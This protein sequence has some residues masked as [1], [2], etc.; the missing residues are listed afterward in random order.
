MSLRI[1]YG[2]AGSGKSEFCFEEI[3]SKQNENCYMITPEQF[4]F[5]AEQKLLETIKTGSSI[6]SEVI[7]F[8]RMANRVL[9]EVGGIT[10]NILSENGKK[11]LLYDILS[12]GKDKLTF[13]GKSE[14]NV[15]LIIKTLTEFKKHCI[16]QDTLKQTIEKVQDARLKLKLQD[17]SYCYD[18]FQM[19]LGTTYIEENDILS[20]LPEKLEHSKMFDESNVYIDEF[21]GFTLQEYAIIEAILKKAKT[22]TVTI[23]SD[24]IKNNNPEGLFYFNNQMAQRLMDIA[25]KH[26]IKVEQI[27]YLNNTHRFKN[28]ELKA[29]EENL[30]AYPERKYEE[31]VKNVHIS[32]VANPYAEIEKVASQIITLVKDKGYLFR[33][34]SVITKNTESYGALIK[35]IFRS[36]DIPNFIDE[37]KD[38]SQNILIR[39]ILSV[40]E[41]LAKGWNTETVLSSIKTGFY[42]I[43]EEEQYELE[44]Y[45]VAWG[46]KGKTWYEKDW[47]YGLET[48]ETKQKI[49]EIRKKV[50]TPIIRLKEEISKEKTIKNVCKKLYEFLKEVNV[51][52]QVNNKVQELR[53]IGEVEIANEYISSL[54][55]VT[56]ILDEMV[57]WLGDES[58]S[59]EKQ[60][61]LFK[62]GFSGNVLGAIPAT[63]DQVIIGDVERSRSHKVKAVFI[64]GLN[65]G[66]FPSFNKE[67]GFLNDNDRHVLNN[68]GVELAKDSI[69]SLYE[70]QFSIYKAFTVAEEELYLSY[71]SSDKEGTSLRPSS[72]ISKIKKIFPMI[73]EQSNVVSRRAKYY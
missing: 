73:K 39:Y 28:Q 72:L 49:N 57:L 68:L 48:E 20:V 69:Q 34:I 33:D 26:N 52:K 24:D 7:T 67:E 46:V 18:Q 59:F 23:A 45:V 25:Q 51:E 9:K 4:S 29:I 41:I 5:T 31:T 44:N 61:A 2:R 43:S 53:K 36:Y 14:E 12:N 30:Y 63:L 60:L 70:E 19:K 42:P 15:E 37:K 40:L 27:V 66:V 11:M 56:K 1:I 35:A 16:S 32:L 38:L 47:Y 58:I 54:Q 64:I 6:N 62:I 50:V 55:I 65:D 10:S 17:I 8:G 22:L 71:P 21:A 13:L 3:K